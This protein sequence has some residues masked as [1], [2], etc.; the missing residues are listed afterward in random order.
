MPFI[1]VIFSCTVCPELVAVE[2]A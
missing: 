1:N 2:H